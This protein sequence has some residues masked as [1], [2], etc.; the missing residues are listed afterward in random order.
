M[1]GPPQHLQR[2]CK[3]LVSQY[4]GAWR[5]YHASLLYSHTS[6]STTTSLHHQQGPTT[7]EGDV[8]QQNDRA[9]RNE[10]SSTPIPS[11]ILLSCNLT[12]G[13][14][15]QQHKH[16]KLIMDDTNNGKY[17]CLCFPC[18]ISYL[19]GYV[20]AKKETQYYPILERKGFSSKQQKQI[21]EEWYWISF[22]RET[23]VNDYMRGQA[24]LR[25]GCF[26]RRPP[27]PPLHRPTTTS[28]ASSSGPSGPGT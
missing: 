9:I 18:I 5:C 3:V 24:N 17:L 4:N 12:G 21:A 6:T 16:K 27:P 19:G 8:C 14:T 1:R 2:Q 7:D 13:A 10:V 25:D 11:N 22:E 28:P 23:Q 15:Q 20:Y 26:W